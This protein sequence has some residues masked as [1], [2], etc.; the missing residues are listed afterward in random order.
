MPIT[1]DFH[2]PNELQCS[3]D[4]KGKRDEENFVT[5]VVTNKRFVPVSNNFPTWRASVK[6]L[7]AT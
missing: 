4:P 1:D 7:L 6:S 5:D 2:V 3:D